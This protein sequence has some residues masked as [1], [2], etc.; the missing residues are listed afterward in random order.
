[1]E[2]QTYSNLPILQSTSQARDPTAFA[3]LSPGSQG[4]LPHTAHR[5]HPPTH[6]GYLYLDG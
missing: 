1:M 4:R 5:W 2:N 3:T 6:S